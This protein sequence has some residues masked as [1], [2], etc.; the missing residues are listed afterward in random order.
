M[1]N[2]QPSADQAPVEPDAPA[3]PPTDLPPGY[4][5][6]YQPPPEP[7]KPWKAPR[8]LIWTTV[9]WAVVLVVSGTIYALRGK[10]TVREQTTIAGS[11]TTVDHAIGNVVKAAGPGPIVVLG[12]FVK[13]SGCDI[14]PVRSGVE[15][16]RA[17]DLYAAPGSESATL[18]A[19]A[20]GLPPSYAARVGPGN[21]LDLNADAGDFVG[22]IGAAPGPG[23]IEVKAETGCRSAGEA[24]AVVPAPDLNANEMAPVRAVLA[25]L[26]ATPASTSAAQIPCAGATGT[27]RTVS[28]HATAASAGTSL[29]ASLDKVMQHP[30]IDT[31][32][33]VAYRIGL[34]DVVV[35]QG[36]GGVD[37]SATSRC[38]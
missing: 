38:G 23:Q 20:K 13:V 5:W 8:W 32:N 37:I 35:Q 16:T 12:G 24:I 3:V 15:Y 36:P 27:I 17:V 11:Q 29:K 2:E 26:G 21:V 33:L 30:V 34:S 7:E 25:E 6:A 9:A 14:T 4:V 10:P 31:A 19:I 1:V 18:K 28:V 22:L